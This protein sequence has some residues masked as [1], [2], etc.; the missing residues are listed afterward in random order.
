MRLQEQLE[1][2]IWR[3]FG[4][5]GLSP[6]SG[7]RAGCEQP[8]DTR[9]VVWKA[10]LS[11]L[12]PLILSSR[13]KFQVFHCPFPKLFT[14]NCLAPTVAFPGSLEVWMR[15][16]GAGWGIQGVPWGWSNSSAQ[17]WG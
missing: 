17:S 13:A 4:R 9:L 5:Q 6:V 3:G 14:L 7:C 15:M 12:N 8:L 11:S 10:A 1:A 16:A 2:G